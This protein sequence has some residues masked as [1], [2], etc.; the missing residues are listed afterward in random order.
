MYPETPQLFRALL[1]AAPDAMV[2]VDAHGLIVLVN[3]QAERMFGYARQELL[4]KPVEVLVPGRLRE[5]HAKHRIDYGVSAHPRPMGAGLELHGVR[6]DGTEFPVEISLSPLETDNGPLIASAIRDITDRKLAEAERARLVRERGAHEE[7]SRIKDEFIATLSH[8][9]RTPLNAILGWT[10]LLRES[11]MPADTVEKALDTIERN[12]RAQVQLVDDLLDVS[13]I[14]SGKL[15]LQLSPLDVTKTVQQ[16]VEVVRPTSQTRRIALV[17]HFERA[18]VLVLGDPDRLQQVLWNLL[19]NALK[20]T[21]PGGRV[22]VRVLREGD[23][24]MI[25]V[26]DTGKGIR[27]DFLPYVFDRFKQADSS[28]TRQEGGLGLG[29]A[30]V[31]SIVEMHGGAVDV[32]SEGSGR[33]ATFIVSLP[34]REIMPQ[35]SHDRVGIATA[36][37]LDGV[38]VLIVDDQADERELF[39]TIL[40]RQGATVTAAASAREAFDLMRRVQPDI[41]VSDIAMPESDGNAF[42][43]RVR[44][45]PGG[46]GGGTPAVAVTAHA[47]A[48]DRA[49][50]LAAGFQ[51]YV[52][53]PVDP[54]TL[55]NEI[56]ATVRAGRD[57]RDG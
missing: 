10:R 29:L 5:L 25:E 57:R 21:A 45:L 17:T 19:S 41:I 42:I 2:I 12:C 40:E 33:G 15:Q 13:R 11:E 16:A 22:D 38:R 28:S 46:L 9:L 34:A 32:V 48:S 47:R 52:P 51:R 24:A 43:A 26:R 18:P 44:A 20:F 39:S 50:A 8:E 6:N 53:K 35:P 7:A 36:A 37:R 54:T 27:G 55:I 49:R 23:R 30:L 4:G 56:A 1:E 3:A 31:R 14:L